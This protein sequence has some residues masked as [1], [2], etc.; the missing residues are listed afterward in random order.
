MSQQEALKKSI[1]KW[2]RIVSGTGI[3]KG[4]E[5]CE[6]CKDN[7]FCKTCVV[8]QKTKTESC[9]YTPYEDWRDHHRAEH[10]ANNSP[11]EIYKVL[12]PT[13]KE[14]AQEEVDFL[15]GLLE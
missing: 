7:A 12:C 10:S 3:D 5:N 11:N 8:F 1:E 15:K 4:S 13:C 9:W 6:L 14:I 2:K